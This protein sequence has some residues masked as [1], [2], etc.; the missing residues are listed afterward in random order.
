LYQKIGLESLD[1]IMSNGKN[2][3]KRRQKSDNLDLFSVLPFF[4]L[5]FLLSLFSL[6]AAEG[7]LLAIT[8]GVHKNPV[9][10]RAR[11]ALSCQR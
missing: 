8:D 3:F 11:M 1:G 4:F 7:A 6:M 2:I 9:K 5:S 10:R